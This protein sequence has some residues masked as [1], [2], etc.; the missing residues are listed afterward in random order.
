MNDNYVTNFHNFHYNLAPPNFHLHII[1]VKEE[2]YSHVYVNRA[3][4]GLL[5]HALYRTNL[6]TL[7][8]MMGQGANFEIEL[9]SNFSSGALATDF[10]IIDCFLIR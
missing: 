8:E 9:D 6:S 7:Y 5:C 3:V 1:Q 4:E 10:D 2:M